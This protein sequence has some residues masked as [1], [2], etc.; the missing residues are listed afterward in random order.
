MERCTSLFFRKHDLLLHSSKPPLSVSSVSFSALFLSPSWSCST[1]TFARSLS[2]WHAFLSTVA[3]A[4]TG[5]HTH[6]ALA[7]QT[8]AN[9]RDKQTHQ[10]KKKRK[11][12]KERKTPVS[13]F[14][15]FVFNV[16]GYFLLLCNRTRAPVFYSCYRHVLKHSTIWQ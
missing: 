13:F 3:Q 5:M 16:T 4:P 9:N 8:Y 12:E 11:K 6:T 10:E 15:V 2:L 1:C 14:W 7:T